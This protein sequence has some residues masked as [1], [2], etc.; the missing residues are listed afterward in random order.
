MRRCH[1]VALAAALLAVLMMLSGCA[2]TREVVLKD[3]MVSYETILA[4]GQPGVSYGPKIVDKVVIR[5]D[6]IVLYYG[7]NSG[8]FVPL[9]SR[10][11][12]FKWS[13]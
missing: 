13:R 2:A 4:N 6:A 7:D 5:P 10:M 12:S 1:I 8:V 9:D 3:V 11:K